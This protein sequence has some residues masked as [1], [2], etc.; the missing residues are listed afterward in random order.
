MAKT[1]NNKKTIKK[2]ATKPVVVIRTVKNNKP[3]KTK[4]NVK[5]AIRKREERVK[6]TKDKVDKVDS[7]KRF[8]ALG[9]D[10]IA[11]AER[12]AKDK[13]KIIEELGKTFGIVSNAIAKAK[14]SNTTFYKWYKEDKEFR[15]AVD[16]VQEGF[17]V[18]VED[19]LKQKIIQNDGHSIRF[20]LSHRV[21]KYR[22]KM[23]LGQ[24]EDLEPIQMTIVTRKTKPDDK[25]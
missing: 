12:V 16:D 14:I 23:G 6:K 15:K 13:A 22:P 17:D 9:R 5:V 10:R 24:D 4:F 20:Y 11:V 25:E 7:N 8:D 3:L 2:K 19:K 21:K 1:N 18:I